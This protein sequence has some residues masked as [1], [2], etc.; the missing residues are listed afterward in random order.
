MLRLDDFVKSRTSFILFQSRPIGLYL[1]DSKYH[2]ELKYSRYVLLMTVFFVVEIWG[3]KNNKI[4]S[5]CKI[6]S[7]FSVFIAATG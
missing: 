3:Y 1:S 7:K 4:N 6:N 2:T 5:T